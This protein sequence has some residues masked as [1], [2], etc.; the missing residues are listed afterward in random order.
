VL[1]CT[2]IELIFEVDERKPDDNLA[3]LLKGV[4]QLW[5]RTKNASSVMMI[6]GL[7]VKHQTKQMIN[8][9]SS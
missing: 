7:L 1:P 5:T 8:N 2:T 3:L 4:S 6:K 9:L